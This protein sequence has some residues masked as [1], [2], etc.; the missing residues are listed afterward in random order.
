MENG[1]HTK[2]RILRVAIDLFAER[3]YKEVTMREIAAEVGVKASSLYKHYENKERIL[4]S[5]FSLLREQMAKA[6]IPAGMLREYVLAV[7]PRKYLDD[8]FDL[9]RNVMWSAEIIKI[10]KIMI[11]EQQRS[12]AAREFFMQELIEGPNRMLKAALDLM[13]E[14]GKIDATDTRTLAE[15]Y[16]AYIIYLCFEQN[17]LKEEPD[18]GEIEEKMRR[19]NAFYADCVLRKGNKK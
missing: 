4:Q 15:E 3:G 2:E 1:V 5:I 8:S 10:S 19:H 7:S 12:H 9:F 16:N 14:S 6:N 17:F 18:L 11:K 13:V